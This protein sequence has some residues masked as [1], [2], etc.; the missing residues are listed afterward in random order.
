MKIWGSTT[1]IL[2][3][4]E[5]LGVSNDNLGVFIE[6]LGLSNEMVVMLGFYKAETEHYS[7][8]LGFKGEKVG[9]I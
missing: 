4:N 5:K 2:G 8:M 6:K 9:I 1:K 7:L 3:L